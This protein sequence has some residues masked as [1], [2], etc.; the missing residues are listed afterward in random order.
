[1]TETLTK[2]KSVLK[3]LVTKETATIIVVKYISA[4]PASQVYNTSIYTHL[5][6]K[7]D[8]DKVHLIFKFWKAAGDAE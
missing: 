1:M 6:P 4:S 5:P 7:G 3:P 8:L 2:R